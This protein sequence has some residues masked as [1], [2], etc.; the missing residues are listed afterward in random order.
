MKILYVTTVG[1]MM[2]FFKSLI[3]ELV[4]EGNLVD[5]ATNE[6]SSSVPNFFRELGCRIYHT[7]SSRSPFSYGNIKAIRQIRELV[8]KN[9]YDIVHCHSPLAAASTRLACRTLRKKGKVKV[10]YTAHGFHFYKGAPLKNWLIFYPIEKICSRYTDVLITI[11]KED[12]KLA[13]RKMMAKIV[14][15]IP[16]VGID[17]AKFA[18]VDVDRKAKRNEIGVPEDAFM[19]LSVGELNL[20]KNHSVVIKALAKIKEPNIHYVIAGVGVEK[21]SLQQLADE[22]GVNLHLL[23]Y[24]QDIP[25]LDNTADCYILPSIREGLNV[26]IMEAM[27]SGLPVICSRIRG[28]IDMVNEKGGELFDPLSINECMEALKKIMKRDRIQLGNYNLQKAKIFSLNETN[29]QMKEMY[30]NSLK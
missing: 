12:Y 16:G 23:G 17:C 2:T 15:Y 14:D 3:G 13:K 18:N 11:N 24:R 27:A 30:F 6:S 4:V 26:S 22:L 25:E 8:E 21:D 5:V 20:N 1:G 9:G 29:K 19:L 10:I 28:N 7:D